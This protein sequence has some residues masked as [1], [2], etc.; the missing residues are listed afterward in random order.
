MFVNGEWK[1]F[2]GFDE[3]DREYLWRRSEALLLQTASDLIG[4]Y[5]GRMESEKIIQRQLQEKELLIRETHHRIKNN[6]ASIYGLLHLQAEQIENEEARSIVNEAVSRVNSMKD[7]YE[8]MLSSDDIRVVSAA[9]Y[10]NDLIDSIMPLFS[11][12]ADVTVY[13]RIA[14]FTLDSD[15]LFL[16]GI[17]VNEVVTNAMKYAF[18]GRETG[19]IRVYCE[20]TEDRVTLIIQNNGIGL[21]E[22]F[23]AEQ[24]GGLGTSLVTMLTRQLDGTV[25]FESENG[26]KVTLEFT[27]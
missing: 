19:T 15:K 24:N 8:K 21:P 1:G 3:I 20:K 18:A 13:K 11:H 16:L 5:L 12:Q 17:I 2:I 6:I 22:G 10:I 14:D 23:D 27:V 26:M 25:T 9:P 7:L 4:G